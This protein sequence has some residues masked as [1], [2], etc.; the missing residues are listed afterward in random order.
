MPASPIDSGASWPRRAARAARRT[1]GG[2]PVATSSDASASRTPRA[3]PSVGSRAE[4]SVTPS[5]FANSTKTTARRIAS[6]VAA[7]DSA[8]PSSAPTR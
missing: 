5:R 1:S 2:A 7:S 6:V 4:P 8:R 3:A